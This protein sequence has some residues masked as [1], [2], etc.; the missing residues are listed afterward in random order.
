MNRRARQE[1]TGGT[2]TG[3]VVA[4]NGSGRPT[5]CARRQMRYLERLR[6][7]RPGKGCESQHQVNTTALQRT[8][9]GLGLDLG[10]LP[11]PPL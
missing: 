2:K 11:G 9:G 3:S 10:R 7:C 4:E 6:H 8:R 1:E 5:V